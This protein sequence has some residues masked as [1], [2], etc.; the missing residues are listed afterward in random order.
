[1]AKGK[2]KHHEQKESQRQV[3]AYYN[4]SQILNKT[5]NFS[6]H[7]LAPHLV[8][9]TQHGEVLNI[10]ETHCGNKTIHSLIIVTTKVWANILSYE[11][12][13]MIMI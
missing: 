4:Q 1:M 12:I 10:Q 2:L 3:K 11:M 8:F 5:N 9:W 6:H 13:I 7:L